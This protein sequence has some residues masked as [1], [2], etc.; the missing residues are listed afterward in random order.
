[1][2]KR[3]K[4]VKYKKPL[5]INIGVVVFAIILIYFCVYLFSYLTA[6]HI[7]VYEVQ[8]GQ[9]AQTNIYTGLILR[10]ETVVYADSTGAINYY[11][12]EGDKAGKNDLVCSLDQKGTISEQISKAG[13][14]GSKLDKKS[15]ESIENSIET[16]IAECSDMTFYNVYSFKN[17]IDAQ[18]QEAL[19][20]DALNNLTD[21][22]DKAVKNQT[23]KFEK[24][25]V[26][27]VVAFY[28]DGYEEITSETFKHSMFD[29]SSYSKNNLKNSEKV[30]NGQALFKLSTNEDWDILVPIDAD[31]AKNLKDE[32]Y[33]TVTF[34][35]DGT[36]ATP[37]M[38]MK[39]YD[40]QQ[41]LVLSFNS[42][43]VRFISDR[44]V[45]LEIGTNHESGLKIPNTSIVE[46]EFFVIPK[47]YLTYGDDDSQPG[48]LKVNG[49]KGKSSVEFF[50]TDLYYET[51]TSYYIDE[52]DLKAGDV[53]QK[54]GSSD[55]Y[56]LQKTAKLKGVYNINKGYAVFK[57]ID[58][59][60]KN[61]EYSIL[62][63]GTSYGL[64]LYDHIA[65]NG[66]EISEGELIN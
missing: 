41:Y 25:P 2:A 26:D 51:E 43:M 3:K 32:E 58:I 60:S 45:E 27:G 49:K 16:Y 5:H 18:V 30:S 31:M 35:K 22:T 21:Q 7:A 4:I 40:G 44:Y 6:K 9:I 23:F 53:I 57:Q 20:L 14:D 42:S 1:M 55:Q 10:D 34:R 15:L 66:N 61:E 48:V 11:M 52:T 65:L 29:P 59:L 19:Y 50:T 64:S 38:K 12:K 8:K 36:T 24:S 47:S 46:K 56:T 33:V 39:E 28:T 37:A 62:K 63:T 17:S 13:L 54:E